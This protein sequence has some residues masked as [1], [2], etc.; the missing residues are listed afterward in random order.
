M[1]L[2]GKSGIQGLT[3]EVA[4]GNQKPL[5]NW[6]KS[7]LEEG[8][9]EILQG[10]VN[11]GMSKLINPRAQTATLEERLK[12]G[13]LGASVG[14]LMGGPS[15][16]QSS[17]NT[18]QNWI[19]GGAQTSS[20]NNSSQGSAANKPYI[21][22]EE[23]ADQNG[24][25]WNNVDYADETTKSQIM[26]STHNAMVADGAVVTVPEAVMEEVGQHFP[27]LRG[28]K[29]KERTPILKDAM[30][31][32]K[33]KLRE[34]L[35]GFKNQSFEF[36][37]S[38]KI[39]E[40]K[41]YT[42]GINEVM[43]KVTQE[44]A[45]MLYSTPAIFKNARYLYSTQDYEGDPN[46]YR[47]NYFYA[48]VQIGENTVGVRIA[49]RDVIQ[50][51]G[52]S[53]ESQI[54]NWGI[55]KGTSLGG[56]QPV[57]SN[58]S[59]G[60]SSDVPIAS[61]S[62]TQSIVKPA[63]EIRQGVLESA[64]RVDAT[65]QVQVKGETAQTVADAAVA[66]NQKV[67][68]A[69][70]SADFV[71]RGLLG[72]YDRATDTVLLNPRVPDADLLGY[73]MAHEMTH[74]AE[75]T[76][77][78]AALQN[79]VRR[80]VGETE[81]Q[82]MVEETRADYAAAGIPLADNVAVEKEVL[83]DWVGE[84]LFKKGFAQMIVN[85]D[86]ST[87][88]WFVRVID[89]IRRALGMKNSQSA[90]NMANLE[91][92]FM[93]AIE[94]K[95]GPRSKDGQYAIVAL[96][97]GKIYVQADRKVLTGT[98]VET[99]RSQIDD[100]FNNVILKNGSLTVES[101]EGDQLTI[102]KDQTVWKGKDDHSLENGVRRPLRD[103]EYRVKLTALSHIDELAEASLVQR[104]KSG[105]RKVFSDEKS[106]PFA[107]DGFEYRTVYFKDFDGLYYRITLSV[108]LNDGIATIY[109][110][111]QI[112][113]A[114]APEG[115][116]ISAIGSK[117][118]GAT[119]NTNIPQNVDGVNP[120]SMQNGEENSQYAL[121]RLSNATGEV[122]VKS[123]ASQSSAVAEAS[124]REGD[125][126]GVKDA[127]PYNA[128]MSEGQ[129]LERAVETTNR[130]RQVTQARD[131]DGIITELGDDVAL[132][133]M[134][135][136][137]QL[138]R[139]TG[140]VEIDGQ[141]VNADA[142]MDAYEQSLPDDPAALEREIRRLEKLQA[143]EI[144]RQQ[145]EGTLEEPS[146]TRLKINLQLFAA[147]R[148]WELLQIAPGKEGEK[149]RRFYENRLK[150]EDPIHSDEL[151]ELLSGRTEEYDPVSNKK[152]L[153]KAEQALHNPKYQAKLLRKMGRDGVLLNSVDVAAATILAKD[154]FNEG[155]LNA[156][157]DIYSGLARRGTELGRAVQALSMIKRLTPEGALVAATRTLKAEAD[158]VIGEGANEGLDVLAEDIADRLN[159]L[160]KA[161]ITKPGEGAGTYGEGSE[162]AILA[163]LGKIRN[164][165]YNQNDKVE[166][167]K[168]PDA[169]AQQLKEITGTDVTGYKM[170]V[171]ARILDHIL[172][173]H[174]RSGKADQLMADDVDVARMGNVLA[175]PDEI[176]QGD[177]STAYFQFDKSK[178]KNRPSPTVIYEKGE[179]NLSY[180]VIHTVTDSKK[181][182]LYVVTAFRGKPGYKKGAQQF[183]DGNTPGDTAKTDAAGTPTDIVAQSGNQVKA[184][185]T[186]S[187][188]ELV[189]EL[190]ENLAREERNYLSKDEIYDELWKTV[191]A[192]TDIP[193]QVKRYVLKK[194]RKDDGAL[195]Q[196]IYQIYLKGD[197]SQ[198]KIRRAM[199]EALELPTL[200]NE[201]VITMVEM[202]TRV[203]ELDADP[204]A[205]AEAM[206]EL[207]EFLG[208]KMAVNWMDRLQAW[209]KFGMLAN[210]KTH[211]RN[212]SSNYAYVPI[213]K[214][215]DLVAFGL[216]RLFRVK[217]EERAAYLGWSH[218]EH[219]QSIMPKLEQQAK[220]AALEMQKKGAKYETG[221]GRLK[222]YRKH[223]GESKVGEALNKA[224]KWNSEMLEREDLRFFKPA[225]IDALGQM[226]TARK[227]TE[228]TP[229]MHELAMKRA[230][231]ATFRADN[232][233]SDVMSNL[234]KFQN[235][236]TTGRRLFGQAVDVVIPFHK[237]PANIAAQSV[238]HSPVGI[239][240]GAFDLWNATRGK[241]SKDAATAINTMA[242]GVTGTALYAIAILLGKA[243]IIR[244]G[245]GKSEKERDKDELAGLQENALI[246][247]DVS[248]S[249][250]WLQPAAAPLISGA[251]VG[252]AMA[253][254]ELTLSTVFGATAEGA[255]S[256]LELSML[257]SLYDLFGG[258]DNGAT[259]SL[260]SIG[261]N[262]LSQSI[263]TLVGQLARAIDPVQRE[264]KG[265]NA[266]ETALNQVMAK[267]PGLTYFLD[268]KL[269]VWGNEVYRTGQ[270]SGTGA[271]VNAVQQPV[272]PWNTKIGLA[273]DDP[274]NK[275]ILRLYESTDS[276]SVIP[277][278][279]TRDE[280]KDN[281]LDYTE[282]NRLLGSYNRAAVE[283][284][285]N[286]EWPY[287]V[288]EELPNGKKRNV[289][290]YYSE[291][292]DDERRR[293]LDRIYGIT[294]KKVMG[295]EEE[296][297]SKSRQ[298][299]YFEQ[300]FEEMKQ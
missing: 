206:E 272:T 188:E 132:R 142:Y 226:M 53:G 153:G 211:L 241:G 20:A 204:V 286:D 234:K 239:A 19:D 236:N 63:A 267:I 162:Q 45:D 161:K 127:A 165:D 235:A 102:T 64:A 16:I 80:M 262:V 24:S 157:A 118:Q 209:R 257:Q 77:Q 125:L 104:D 190:A 28:M 65:G 148:K 214:A 227:A 156:V 29:K 298:D 72:M 217:P 220:L 247:G 59:H 266:F 25:V 163:M 3:Q 60:A 23:F 44:K 89:K 78:L 284:F 201:D 229:Q 74:S 176:R 273:E 91:R 219:G 4:E 73:T 289:T 48:P 108:G 90:R 261:E 31:T 15:A 253:E 62:E 18:A 135:N 224:N 181:K 120:Q 9:E 172:R 189:N 178:G 191:E 141:T 2:D 196:R 119:A 194:L 36:E 128:P 160:S 242:K 75:G 55:K 279:I 238:L 208:S 26:Q 56:V 294:K 193:E 222:N 151:T 40:A 243:G 61:I 281:D 83:A 10:Y 106:H 166:F 130:G 103:N 140:T 134:Y 205:Q 225:Y 92:L 105:A 280:A 270:N 297:K 186:I 98:D 34:F 95:Q 207:Y 13:A 88:N 248:I 122:V 231:D 167:G 97:D 131:V 244:T 146:S 96:E 216:E 113:E 155:D 183:T 145:E 112:K 143:E 255:D 263:P 116:I 158:Y 250:D 288:Q 170:V 139:P 8:G 173:D 283:D 124:L 101:I 114:V 68:F 218:T 215:D 41:L 264:T 237:T 51:E 251:A 202:A 93:Q 230:L 136:A 184:D 299:R 195:A 107:K 100:F 168:V 70:V 86:V 223:F 21:S 126:R 203:Q 296:K 177:P 85:G 38:G 50:N 271:A 200:S 245:Y 121:R 137:S 285:L 290:K 276:L 94:N 278:T 144:I 79:T 252:E 7:S 133:R 182:T 47:W 212:T 49:V 254:E 228:I 99:W 43:E 71:Q 14:A 35:G 277:G 197:L 175:N 293:V 117:A 58:S 274:I 87:G 246:I 22:L 258:Y 76:R 159:R 69:P 185:V 174:G 152:T 149:A 39:L 287:T 1:G 123:D 82:R 12:E 268:P 129:V 213:R 269:D 57:V 54:Y 171:E 291:M 233:L 179:G 198:V 27:D 52:H 187:R 5:L 210:V 232:A 6:I 199:E 147:H 260:V 109:N 111:G 300:L 81:W 240:K 33:G 150:G 110:I 265:D 42:T 282:V 32:L 169:I 11:D 37:V 295:T 256:L 84:N 67:Q 249:L 292:T 30:N 115:S 138:V 164:G 46:I 180:Y 221:T 259:G 275:E 154:A 17:L 66:L 192:C